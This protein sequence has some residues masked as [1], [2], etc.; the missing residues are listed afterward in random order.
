MPCRAQLWDPPPASQVATDSPV[1]PAR[2]VRQGLLRVVQSIDRR[3]LLLVGTRHASATRGRAL[4][5][6]RL[7]DVPSG[8]K[9]QRNHGIG[10]I[11]PERYALGEPGT[12]V[13]GRH[14][15]VRAAGT[16]H[17]E[18][19]LGRVSKQLDLDSMDFLIAVDEHVGVG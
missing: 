12:A 14:N 2:V 1:L 19:L 6:L 10:A 16:C 18:Y 13:G 4:A 11:R 17:A 3:I 7:K 15:Q 9:R 5:V 8:Y